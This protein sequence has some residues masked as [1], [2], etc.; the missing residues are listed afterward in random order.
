[1]D[2]KKRDR[3]IKEWMLEEAKNGIFEEAIELIKKSGIISCASVMRHFK[4]GY[5]RAARLLDQIEKEGIIGPPKDDS[6]LRDVLVEHKHE[7]E[8]WKNEGNR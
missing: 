4:V 8:V 3:F 6:P 5:A 7:K 2:Q 1:M